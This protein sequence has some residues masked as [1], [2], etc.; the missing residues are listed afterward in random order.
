MVSNER[1][2]RDEYFEYLCS[3]VEDWKHQDYRG[4]LKELD[5][6]EFRW[7]LT[8]DSNRAIDGKNL[9]FDFCDYKGYAYEMVDDELNYPCSMLEMLVALAK[10][11]EDQIMWDPD[12]GNRTHVWFWQFID[13]LGLGDE[14]DY[15]W[16]DESLE[17]IDDFVDKFM[18]RNYFR[19]GFGGLFPL[20]NAKKD[21]KKVEIWYQLQSWLL[22]NY[23]F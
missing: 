11:C 9:R 14:S 16:N 19:D 15:N 22:E 1:T 13:N 18:S 5:R 10:R 8:R 21:Q 7:V 17:K 3:L 12:K 2:I 23:E 20:K 4:L 6:I